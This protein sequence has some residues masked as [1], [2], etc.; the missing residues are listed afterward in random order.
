MII[1]APAKF[2]LVHSDEVNSSG[3][4]VCADTFR[5][6]KGKGGTR[7]SPTSDVSTLRIE[8]SQVAG[9]GGSN[10]T[11]ER[12]SNQRIRVSYSKSYFT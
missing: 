10:A 2:S 4:A 11:V 8:D 6:P 1:I 3:M 7:L 5:R 9:V 12:F